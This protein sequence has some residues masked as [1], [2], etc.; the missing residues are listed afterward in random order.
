VITCETIL[1]SRSALVAALL[2]G[3]LTALQPACQTTGTAAQRVEVRVTEDG[4]YRLRGRRVEKT[5][6]GR[7][8]AAAGCGPQTRITVRVPADTTREAMQ[9]L[10]RQLAGA[11]VQ[12]FHFETERQATALTAP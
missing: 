1:R 2:V 11:G 4:A 6:I 9:E 8:L 5:Q 10:A 12:R 7:A 3:A